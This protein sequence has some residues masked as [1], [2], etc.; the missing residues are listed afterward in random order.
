[1]ETQTGNVF[2]KRVYTD[3][4]GDIVNLDEVEFAHKITRKRKVWH[5]GLEEAEVR[6][7]EV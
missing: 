2:R 6:S 7:A 3:T 1:M 5:P 4:N